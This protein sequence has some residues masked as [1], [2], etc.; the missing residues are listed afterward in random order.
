MA[1]EYTDDDSSA[2]SGKARP[3][4]DQM[5]NDLDSGEALAGRVRASPPGVIP[6]A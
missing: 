5:L 6:T 3:S 4:Y 1:E 2:Y